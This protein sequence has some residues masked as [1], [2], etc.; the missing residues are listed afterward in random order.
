MVGFFGIDP[1]V[2]QLAVPDQDVALASPELL[3]FRAHVR[4]L[5]IH[6]G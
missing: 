6:G 3:D 4:D 1:P 2:H 5:A